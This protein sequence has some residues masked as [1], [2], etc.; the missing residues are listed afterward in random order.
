M[1]G[2]YSNWRMV[3]GPHEVLLDGRPISHVIECFTGCDGW[4]RQAVKDENG[5]FIIEGD[6]VRT[7]VLHGRV[8]LRPKTEDQRV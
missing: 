5:N 3:R 2:Q 1:M 7:R 6:E 8:T 4:L